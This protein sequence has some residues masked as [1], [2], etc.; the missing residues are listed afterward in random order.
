MTQRTLVVWCPDWPVTAALLSEPGRAADEVVPAAVVHA[1]L[2]VACSAAARAE[3]VQRGLRRREA[4]ARCPGL[5]VVERDAG[6]EARAFEPVVATLDS[7]CPRIEILRP[8]CCAFATRGPSRYFGGDE[9]LTAL[10]VQTVPVPCRVG[11]AD[12]PFAAL[13]AA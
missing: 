11:V 5:V 4:Q 7:L 12:G 1:N 13:L 3:G 10:V 6:A 9:A 2:V 8:G